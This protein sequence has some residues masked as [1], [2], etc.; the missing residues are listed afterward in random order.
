MTPNETTEERRIR[1]LKALMDAKEKGLRIPIK[2][3]LD[4]LGESDP[5]KLVKEWMEENK[6]R[7]A[8]Q[9]LGTKGRRAMRRI[10]DETYLPTAPKMLEDLFY[11]GM[12]E[13]TGRGGKVLSARRAKQLRHAPLDRLKLR[14]TE[15]YRRTVGRISKTGAYLN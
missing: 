3:I 7:N 10:K 4:E 2:A 6:D 15:R 8:L 1:V 5:G 11:A 13:R 12:V 14:P 9:E